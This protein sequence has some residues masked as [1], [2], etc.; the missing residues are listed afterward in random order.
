MWENE[1]FKDAF[2]SMN[3]GLVLKKRLF[4][5]MFKNYP[6]VPFWIAFMFISTNVNSFWILYLF[7]SGKLIRKVRLLSQT[8]LLWESF[9]CLSVL[10]FV[11][12]ER[13]GFPCCCFILSCECLLQFWVVW[14]HRPWCMGFRCFWLAI[15]IV[16]WLSGF[17]RK[18]I[19]VCYVPVDIVNQ[20]KALNCHVH[21]DI[22]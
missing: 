13:L 11:F 6:I 3:T 8:N 9:R 10:W 1:L 14:F 18:W 22:P 16:T 17:P 19:N 4:E 15:L 2:K 7:I 20:C 21:E 12:V 5:R